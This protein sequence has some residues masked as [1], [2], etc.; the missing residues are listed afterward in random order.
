MKVIRIADLGI[1]KNLNGVMEWLKVH[2]AFGALRQALP[3]TPSITRHFLAKMPPKTTDT[4]IYPADFDH[5]VIFLRKCH[6][7][8]EGELGTRPRTTKTHLGRK[9]ATCC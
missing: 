2:E 8:K 6:P 9:R 1:K 5:P 4:L 7:S 3:D